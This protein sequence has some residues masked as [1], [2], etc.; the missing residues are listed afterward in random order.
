MSDLKSI[1]HKH[2]IHVE[3]HMPLSG[4]DI[5]EVYKVNSKHKQYVVK[6]NSASSYPDMFGKEA[7]S[8]NILSET[9]SFLIP[10]VLGFGKHDDKT[11]LIIDYIPSGIKT[12]FEEEFALCL[13]KLHRCQ[14]DFYG[15]DFDNFIGRLPQKNLPKTKD[16]TDFYINL[17]LEPQFKMASAKGFKFE[18]IDRLYKNIEQIIPQEKASLIHGDLWSG[19]YLISEKGKPCIYDPAI[20]YAP[21]EMDIAMMKLFGGYPAQIFN[22]YNEVFPLEKNWEYRI[23]L[24]QL[25]YILVH[26]NLFGGAYYSQAQGLIKKYNA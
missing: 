26:V 6:L 11:Y 21:R 23:A 20:A 17:R 10:D 1:F 24:W 15:L 13:A 14:S 9:K 5:N 18:K 2:N 4:G 8:L 19:N 22:T 3:K 7:K 12:N 16:A 25:Y